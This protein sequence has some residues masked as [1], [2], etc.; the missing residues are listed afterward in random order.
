V[1]D[2]QSWYP[3]PTPP[4]RPLFAS[5]APHQHVAYGNQPTALSSRHSVNYANHIN[6]SSET[7]SKPE[8]SKSGKE[9]ATPR[10]RTPKP[11]STAL[12]RSSSFYKDP[13]LGF[14]SNGTLKPIARVDAFVPPPEDMPKLAPV[15]A[16]QTPWFWARS[17]RED[18]FVQVPITPM[19]PNLPLMLAPP[20]P[21]SGAL[22]RRVQSDAS[23]MSLIKAIEPSKESIMSSHPPAP[24]APNRRL[25]AAPPRAKRLGPCLACREAGRIHAMLRSLDLD[26]DELEAVSLPT[27]SVDTSL[28]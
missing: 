9:N 28:S 21:S 8:T 18:R 15:V 23:A 20:P 24:I 3:T 5:G 19:T 10:H 1:P 13:P 26:P 11:T 4:Y 25:A 6:E 27:C 2:N 22:V 12:V 7:P 16:P 14:R 17:E